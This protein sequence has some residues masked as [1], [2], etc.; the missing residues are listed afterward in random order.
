M[1]HVLIIE[2]EA[3]IALDL[4]DIYEAAGATSFDIAVCEA[5]ALSSAIERRPQIISSDVNLGQG[6]SGPRAIAN[7]QLTLGPIPVI[8]ITASPEDCI[9]ALYPMIVLGKPLENASIC[10]AFARLAPSEFPQFG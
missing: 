1:C 10:A 7:I 5:G 4:M 8:F 2:D 9:P 3:L 6:D